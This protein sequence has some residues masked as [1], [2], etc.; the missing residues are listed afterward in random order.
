MQIFLHQKVLFIGQKLTSNVF[1]GCILIFET[2]FLIIDL[3]R[4]Y[5]L[6]PLRLHKT[7]KQFCNFVAVI[8]TK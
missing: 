7:L 5:R 3:H 4:D 8:E 6:R 2:R 1:G